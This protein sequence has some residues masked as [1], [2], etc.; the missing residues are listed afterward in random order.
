MVDRGETGAGRLKNKLA[1]KPGVGGAGP[2]W[3]GALAA[4]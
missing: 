3:G 2:R 4:R 1:K